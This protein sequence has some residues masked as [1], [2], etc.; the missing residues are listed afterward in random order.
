MKATAPLFGQVCDDNVPESTHRKE[1]T[2]TVML[3]LQAQGPVSQRR[4][5]EL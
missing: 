4:F 2:T 3:L 5:N 1:D